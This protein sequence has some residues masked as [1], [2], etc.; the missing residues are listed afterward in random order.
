MPERPGF[1]ARLATLGR[2][3]PMTGSEQVVAEPEDLGRPIA[4]ATARAGML[5]EELATT[6]QTL[7]DQLARSLGLGSA[8][9]AASSPSAELGSSTRS[10]VA[11]RPPIV[12]LSHAGPPT[13]PVGPSASSAQ[14]PDAPESGAFRYR[15]SVPRV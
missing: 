3:A 4:M 6:A 8:S 5:R 13:P 14:R 15:R 7:V 2:T 10:S 1:V 11:S 12:M 9:P